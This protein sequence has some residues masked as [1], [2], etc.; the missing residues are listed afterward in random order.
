[1]V[2]RRS[3]S[4]PGDSSLC[5]EQAPQ[6]PQNEM[7]TLSRQGGIARND[8]VKGFGKGRFLEEYV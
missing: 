1:M 7:A 2:A 8:D 3:R 6:S 5:S 4:K